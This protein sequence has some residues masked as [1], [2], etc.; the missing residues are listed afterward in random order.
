MDIEHVPECFVRRRYMDAAMREHSAHSPMSSE[1]IE[2]LRRQPLPRFF[3]RPHPASY[4]FWWSMT[5]AALG[6]SGGTIGTCLLSAATVKFPQ[7]VCS[8]FPCRFARPT[9]VTETLA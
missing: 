2:R 5:A 3:G 4:S 7:Q 6:E 1:S 8:S 9:E